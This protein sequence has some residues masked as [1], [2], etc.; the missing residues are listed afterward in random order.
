M[1]F[2]ARHDSA[3][4]AGSK[5]RPYL[6]VGRDDE[7]DAA[8]LAELDDRLNAYLRLSSFPVAVRFLRSWD[9]APPR[10]KRPLKDLNN[11]LTTCQAISFAR[12]F[13]WVMALGREDSSCVLGAM[14]LGLEKRLSHYV[15]GN[16]CIDLYTESLEAGRLSEESVPTLSEGSC[17]GVVTAPLNRCAF[18][19]DS[20]IIYG[21]GAQVMRLGQAY[22]WKRGGTL[23]SEFRGR[24]DCADLAIAPVTT[25]EP[26]M[27][28]P[29]TGDRIFGQVQDHEVA[30]S[31]P[32]SL[33]D[34]ILEGLEATH[35]AGAARYPVT[36]WLN[37]T[38]GFPKSYDD[39]RAMLD[40]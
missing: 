23:T 28:V 35:K 6:A 36:N 8:K 40:E 12:R 38:G 30:F 19:P 26:Q 39:Y 16:L 29:C 18:E 4:Q 31:F 11:R 2:A 13:G 17:V 25:G 7:M 33:M 20:V 5:A 10:A 22:L 1:G 14:A 34:E 32:F 24:I 27:I 15:D 3:P 21:N 9:E 37:Y